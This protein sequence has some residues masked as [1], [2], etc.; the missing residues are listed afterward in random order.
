MPLKDQVRYRQIVDSWLYNRQHSNAEALQDAE[1][2]MNVYHE[3]DDAF[4]PGI[5]HKIE[6][7]MV[8]FFL[9]CQHP[10]EAL[11]IALRNLVNFEY[12]RWYA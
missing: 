12:G 1:D 5:D 8:K 10:D 4:D 11:R 3:E 7:N 2:L 6:D 9:N